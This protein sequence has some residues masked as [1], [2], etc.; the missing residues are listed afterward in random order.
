MDE[1]TNNEVYKQVVKDA[2]GGVMYNVANRDKYD[3]TELLA[4]WDNLTEVQKS[5]ANGI[6]KGAINFLKGDY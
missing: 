2:F 5:S 3:A 1:I 4:K 6:T